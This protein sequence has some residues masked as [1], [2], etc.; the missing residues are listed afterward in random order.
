MDSKDI[1]IVEDDNLDMK[2]ILL[3]LPTMVKKD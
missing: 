3:I 2:D 1:L